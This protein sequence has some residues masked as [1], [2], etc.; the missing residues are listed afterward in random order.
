MSIGNTID[1]SGPTVLLPA[2]S[3]TGA[4]ATFGN[5]P[6][7][8]GAGVL[9]D[10]T[11]AISVTGSPSG[12]SVTLQGSLDGTLWSVLDTS[13]NTSG[14]LR[15]IAGTPVTFLRANLGTLTG[16]SAPTVTVTIQPGA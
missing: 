3:G 11:W 15:G 5:A 10:F 2:A 9:R 4:G 6:T 14:E 7:P 1:P 8:G 16:G 13:T 12:I